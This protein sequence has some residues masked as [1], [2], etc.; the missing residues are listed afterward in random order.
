M[1]SFRRCSSA[2]PGLRVEAARSEMS[3]TQM[4]SRNQ[5]GVLSM[6]H[7]RTSDSSHRLSTA[8]RPGTG[9]WLFHTAGQ[10]IWCHDVGCCFFAAF[11]CPLWLGAAR[12]P[13][14]AAR[15]RN[16]H[17]TCKVLASHSAPLC[18]SLARDAQICQ[19]PRPSQMRTAASQASVKSILEHKQQ[20]RLMSTQTCPYFIL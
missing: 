10:R 6:L 4:L 18:G 14:H 15:T 13:L 3:L 7:S 11:A 1:T 12:Q 9:L 16:A 20:R 2:V 19:E 8:A 17:H 5:P